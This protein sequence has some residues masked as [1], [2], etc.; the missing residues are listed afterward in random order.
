MDIGFKVEE[1]RIGPLMLRLYVSIEDSENPQYDVLN[2]VY[3]TKQ[4]RSSN[5]NSKIHGSLG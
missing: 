2:V 3:V 4:E 1:L 5:I